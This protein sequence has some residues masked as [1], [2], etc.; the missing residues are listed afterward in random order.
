[1]L[2][3]KKNCQSNKLSLMSSRSNRSGVKQKSNCEQPIVVSTIT[4][5]K[6]LT[7]SQ[8]KSSLAANNTFAKEESLPP[9]I[10]IPPNTD[11]IDPISN[12]LLLGMTYPNVRESFR[13]FDHIVNLVSKN[14]FSKMD[15]RD[16]FRIH[17][18]EKMFN[19][20]CFT[21]S[22]ELSVEWHDSYSCQS[23]VLMS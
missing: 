9:I 12:I 1:M 8:D 15:G 3:K 6:H 21:I 16:L 7:C 17:A 18:V 4:Q 2:N 11:K 14:K 5:E 20:S 19:T 22:K 23:H 10:G 13:T